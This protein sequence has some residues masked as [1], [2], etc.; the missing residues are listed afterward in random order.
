[1]LSMLKPPEIAFDD[2]VKTVQYTYDDD[3]W[4]NGETAPPPPNWTSSDFDDGDWLRGP[5]GIQC[6][7]PFVSR[8]CLR[9][10]FRV[11][12][13]A[14][15]KSLKLALIYYGG[16]AV[17]LNGE[18]IG[19]QHLPKEARLA[20]AYPIE[21][22][23]G[24]EGAILVPEGY[25][26]VKP[27]AYGKVNADLVK[28]KKP[29]EEGL[30]RMSL[31]ARTLEVELPARLLRKGVNVLALDIVRAPYHKAI[32]EQKSI[33]W[34]REPMHVMSW[35]TCELRAAELKVLGEGVDSSTSPAG[36]QV[37]NSPLLR[38]D[39]R[40]D[41][42][43]PCEPLRPL[44]F[45][46]PRNG[47]F[48]DKIVVGLPGAIRGLKAAP[49][50]L[51]GPGGVVPASAI[52]VRYA[53]PGGAEY[54][55]E[56]AAYGVKSKTQLSGSRWAA[57]K[58][59]ALSVL[60][61]APPE[62][63]R[64]GP[65]TSSAWT[66]APIWLTIKIPKGATPGRYSGK[67]TVQCEGAK[68]VEVPI[69]F[70]VT[71]WT[72]P[73]PENF[74]TWTEMVQS[75]DTLQVEYG[76]PAWSERHFEL[77][78]RSFRLMREVGSKTLYLPLIC[79][80]NLG[81]EESIV[82]WTKKGDGDYDFDFTLMDKYL[83]VA[84]KDL[85]EAQIVC[86]IVWEIFMSR[87]KEL[88]LGGSH[89]DMPGWLNR[90]KDRM[91]DP[92]VTL[93][94]P[95]P[96]TG[97]PARASFPDYFTDAASKARWRKLFAQL[98][99]RMRKRGLEQAMM[100]G[101]FTDCRAQKEEIDFWRDVTGDMPWVSHAH[102]KVARVAGQ[103]I[104]T[105]YNTSIHDINRPL[106]PAKQR[107][108]GWK[109]DPV[110]W[111]QQLLR[112]GSR[113][114]MDMLPGS[115]WG[116]MTE[117]TLAGGQRGFGRLGGDM[118]FVLKNKAGLRTNRVYDRYPWSCWPNLEL[119]CSLLAPGPDGAVAT[120]HFEQLREGV[121]ECEARIFIEQA[122]CDP[123]RREKLGPDLANRCQA[124]LDERV[125]CDLRGVA[126]YKIG[127]HAY[128]SPYTWWFQNGVAG[129]AWKQSSGWRQRSAAIFALAGEIT[130]KS[131]S[132]PAVAMP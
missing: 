130:R 16:V 83:D 114:E 127:P 11:T 57:G 104:K 116:A 128:S 87:S 59:E 26:V 39:F 7:A 78:G 102:F 36:L 6:R 68:A 119:C 61:D 10:K 91:T 43:D 129:H 97:K 5:V 31:R 28:A 112:P 90:F 13:P 131:Q 79:C 47:I 67:L 73:D 4:L 95:D 22:F 121:Q 71:D 33:C 117:I 89:G 2:G 94:T 34:N 62:E 66:V 19:R 45:G 37:W 53:A 98:R 49:S 92:V 8:T 118:W 111:A 76:V 113:G 82:R 24:P 65:A 80:T 41:R 105:G 84:Q 70:E 12:D 9:G 44:T 69:E 60:L 14:S 17:F 27:G 74:Q 40:L 99:E 35:Y 81:N 72:L 55:I 85:G 15:V 52:R 3:Y 88:S 29:S 125:L 18:E 115:M 64:P 108:Y 23:Q 110:L 50:E 107:S 124:L 103:A 32:D 25:E 20:E 75:P 63:H 30:R 48:S 58:V 100:L 1:M 123:A 46:G 86:F 21:A 77:I 126:E 132:G 101:W 51:R 42:G 96:Q 56:E 120:A 54:G 38:T 93:T 106:D 109:K 122:L